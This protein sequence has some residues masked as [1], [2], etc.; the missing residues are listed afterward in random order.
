[1]IDV[2][3]FYSR[4]LLAVS[5][6]IVLNVGAQNDSTHY[7]YDESGLIERY[8]NELKNYAH[9]SDDDLENV[10]DKIDSLERL[11][12]RKINKALRIINKASHFEID[13]CITDKNSYNGRMSSIDGYSYAPSIAFRSKYGFYTRASFYKYPQETSIKQKL[14]EWSFSCG[15]KYRFGDNLYLYSSFSHAFILYGNAESRALLTN[16]LSF[17]GYY[18]LD[19]VFVGVNYSHIWGGTDKTPAIEKT[20]SVLNLMIDKEFSFNHFMGSYYF[21]IDPSASFDLG[22]DNFLQVRNKAVLADKKVKGG[23]KDTLV[24]TFFGLLAIDLSTNFNYTI[25]N[26][27]FYF[28]P[29]AVIPF[30]V[31]DD[32]NK[33]V[34]GAGTTL[35]Y[36]TV[37]F[38][39]RFK[40]W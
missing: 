4:V 36:F 24:N 30:N 38:T 13:N 34:P 26:F 23:G 15:Y 27:D 18:D 40:L 39:Y 35:Y 33:R 5:F 29:H 8:R 20:A 9:S 37:G 21:S 22:S 16:S 14:P 12:S 10:T 11:E 28:I 32:K 19:L 31:T 3:P 6:L 25:K 2:K 1:M 17:S 7:K